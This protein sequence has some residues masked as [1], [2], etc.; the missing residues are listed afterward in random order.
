MKANKDGIPKG[1][2]K[3]EPLNK[4]GFFPINNFKTCSNC[5]LRTTKNDTFECKQISK[6]T[7]TIKH[8]NKSL[9]Y[10]KHKKP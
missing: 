5:G 10:S 2:T 4:R 7:P 9:T 1:Y 3:G 6:H 8:H